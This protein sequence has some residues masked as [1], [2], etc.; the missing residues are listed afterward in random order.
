MEKA[1]TSSGL[2]RKV[3]TVLDD[4]FTIPGTKMRAGLDPIIGV[5]PGVGDI[6]GGLIGI[7]F[8][9]EA[10][11]QK[12]TADVIISMG[13]N[14]LLE[15][16]IGSIP[17]LGDIFDVTWKANLRNSELIDK[18]QHHKTE[19]TVISTLI[20]W[21]IFTVFVLII[22]G[23]IAAIIGFVNLLFDQLF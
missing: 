2:H 1:K 22:V 14:I 5:I 23:L 21:S 4:S 6:I 8:L 18:Y 9:W 13:F 7:Y 10:S 15:V 19:T 11:R 20:V 3:A 12:L 17:F 16:I